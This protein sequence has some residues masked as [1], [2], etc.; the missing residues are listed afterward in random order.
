MNS[1]FG[2]PGLARTGAGHAGEDS[3]MVRPMRPGNV[4]PGLYSLSSAFAEPDRPLVVSAEAAINELPLS[5]RSRRFIPLPLCDPVLL[6]DRSPLIAA[7][8]ICVGACPACSNV[9]PGTERLPRADL[10]DPAW[11]SAVAPTP[12]FL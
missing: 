6:F 2:A 10:C 4:V 3:P 7:S 5:S 1:T 12:H 8:L 11:W 9:A